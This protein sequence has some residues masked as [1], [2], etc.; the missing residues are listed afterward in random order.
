[1]P[2]NLANQPRGPKSHSGCPATSEATCSTCHGSGARPGTAPV[3]C[4]NC[5]GRGI[6]VGTG[7]QTQMG[8]IA[9]MLQTLRGA[10]GAGFDRNYVQMQVN[11]HREAVGLSRTLVAEFYGA[12]RS[13]SA[14]GVT[15]RWTAARQ[16]QVEYL[17][18]DRATLQGGRRRVRDAH[19]DR[20]R[21]QELGRSAVAEPAR[22]GIQEKQAGAGGQVVAHVVPEGDR[23]AVALR[24]EKPFKAMSG[25]FNDSSPF[26]GGMRYGNARMR[27]CTYGFS[28]TNANGTRYAL[29][30]GHCGT[31]GETYVATRFSGGTDNA[32]EGYTHFGTMRFQRFGGGGLDG[33]LIVN[34][35]SVGLP[36]NGDARAQ[37]AIFDG[38]GTSFEVEQRYVP[39][40]R[41]AFLRTYETSGFL[42]AG[43]ATARLLRLEVETAR[44]HL[45]PFLR[46]AEVTGREPLL[47]EVETF[48][49]AFDPRM[50]VR[51][52]ML[53]LH[54]AGGV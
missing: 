35:G 23:R 53:W 38:E 29:T 15:P 7:M 41:D 52:W 22:C 49:A 43:G 10:A 40:D 21:G 5:R 13:P 48:L 54:D 8:L 47:P 26:Y 20:G 12:R 33:G 28:V 19:A 45:V 3:T 1:M 9:Q 34:V 16:L 46:W 32:G 31:V 30:A 4:T 27:A 36:F 2:P 51:E 6:V 17:T 39:Y 25:R 44:P 11:A 14:Y 37:Y 24:V 50:S 18:A 42:E